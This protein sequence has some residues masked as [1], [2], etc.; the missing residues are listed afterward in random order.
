[1][2]DFPVHG[3]PHLL[4]FYF[5]LTESKVSY[6]TAVLSNRNLFLEIS[7]EGLAEGSKEGLTALLE[8]AEEKIKIEYV[9]ISFD[10]NRKDRA[11]LLRTFGFLGFEMVRPGHPMVPAQND[12]LFMV[13]S[14]DPNS[15]D[16]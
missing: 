4:H 7:D 8:F 16:E 12:V 14:L 2:Q 11:S 1:M 10:K 5:Q 3:K 15:F 6:W 9:F 13:Y